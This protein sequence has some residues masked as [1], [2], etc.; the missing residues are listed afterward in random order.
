MDL[1]INPVIMNGSNYT[2]WEL[3]IETLLKSKGLWK[4]TNTVIPYP[5]DDQKK[6]VVDLW[7]YTNTVI[8]YPIHFKNT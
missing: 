2:L 1:K 5:I 8:P 4:Y 7:Q 6:F 3:D